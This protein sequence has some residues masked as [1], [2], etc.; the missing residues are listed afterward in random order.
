[1]I[2][3][4][5]YSGINLIDNECAI[6]VDPDSVPQWGHALSRVIQMDGVHQRQM[7]ERAYSV[8]QSEL[9]WRRGIPPLVSY[10]ASLGV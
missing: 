2:T 6:V 1:M 3:P 4:S 7:A 9:T 10:L 5:I 8:A